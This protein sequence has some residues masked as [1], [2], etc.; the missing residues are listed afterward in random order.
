[1]EEQWSLSKTYWKGSS[2]SCIRIQTKECGKR[3]P[4]AGQVL[5]LE[6]IGAWV[7]AKT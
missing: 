4:E 5:N 6:L 7:H 2:K 1:M 3:Q